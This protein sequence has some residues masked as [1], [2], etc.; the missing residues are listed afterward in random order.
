[1]I[2]EELPLALAFYGSISR[3]N[4]YR[5]NC[6]SSDQPKLIVGHDR[7]IP[8]Q[9]RVATPGTAGSWAIKDL[10]GVTITTLAP[11]QFERV[12]DDG[13]DYYIWTATDSLRNV[14]DAPIDL[15]CGFY[16]IEA[17]L[18]TSTQ[19][20]EV[21]YVPAER[22]NAGA[23][24]PLPYLMLEWSNGAS[25]GGVIYDGTYQN[26]MFM[27]T[28][29]TRG[30]PR[31]ERDT[32]KDGYDNPVIVFQKQIT[33]YELATGEI[34]NYLSIALSY[35]TMNS[36]VRVVP[37]NG[38]VI[39]NLRNMTLSIE[40]EAETCLDFLDL[41]FE[42]TVIIYNGWNEGATTGG[43]Q[44]GGGGGPGTQ[45]PTSSGVL[46]IDKRET[47]LV[48]DPATGDYY[49]PVPELST[50]AK[51]PFLITVN[52]ISH[53]YVYQVLTEPKRFSGFANNEDIQF[54]KIYAI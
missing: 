22:Y 32:E 42:S 30:T 28:F 11:A 33:Q 6:E 52:N 45:P 51:Y 46:I 15:P 31:V 43:S 47:D 8:F 17:D 9:V 7:V 14:G 23:T 1:M 54:I 37:V 19:Y 3:Q 27:D 26:R 49:L 25:F 4:R 24:P 5:E 36:H 35:L 40:S 39:E 38:G 13:Y 34:P 50:V 12:T 2:I 20:G 48:L 10:Q 16:Y 18:G 29:I 53:T 44:P 21:F 41:K